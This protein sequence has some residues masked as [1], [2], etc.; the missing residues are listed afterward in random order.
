MGI[1][2]YLLSNTFNMTMAV[3][4]V[5]Q[6]V[7]N[8]AAGVLSHDT[9]ID[10]TALIAQ[11]ETAMVDMEIGA[12]VVLALESLVVSLGM[13]L[14]SIV[15]TV[16]CYGRMIEIYL[17]ISVAPIPFATLTNR[18]WGQ[19]GSNYLR[20][21]FAL[22]FQA[23]LMM[24]IGPTKSG[25]STLVNLLARDIVSPT[26]VAECTIRPSIIAKK[27]DSVHDDIIVY[28][29]KND[30]KESKVDCLDAVVN[31]LKGTGS[32]KDEFI[33]DSSETHSIREL[34]NVITNHIFT[35]DNTVITAV[36]VDASEGILSNNGSDENQIFLVDM[37][38]FDGAIVKSEHDDEYLYKAMTER[39]DLILFVQSSVSAIL[40]SSTEYFK[41]LRESCSKNV[42]I[43]LINN[44]YDSKSW[45]KG[46]N[47]D[48][49]KRQEDIAVTA[50]YE[51]GIMIYDRKQN[52]VSIN[53]GM[54][55]DHYFK[56]KENI[57]IVGQE[58]SLKDEYDKFKEFEKI[59]KVNI[60][61]HINEIRLNNCKGKVSHAK[62][63]LVDAVVG[64]ITNLTQKMNDKNNLKNV[65]DGKQKD[66]QKGI[67]NDLHIIEKTD[68]EVYITNK[69]KAIFD[70]YRK[71]LD[72]PREMEAEE[73]NQKFQEAISEFESKLNEE[74]LKQAEGIYVGLYTNI[75]NIENIDRNDIVLQKKYQN[76]EYIKLNSINELVD[77]KGWDGKIFGWQT[78]FKFGTKYKKRERVNIYDGMVSVICN[79]SQKS[80]K[81]AIE[82]LEKDFMHSIEACFANLLSKIIT[83]EEENEIVKLT[84]LK[85]A[86][87][88]VNI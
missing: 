19:I 39:V 72:M 52:V 9:A 26:D 59:L 18:E 16:A 53:L 61:S 37:P 41:F 70:D 15:I 4:D 49:I 73:I 8:A 80:V 85:T 74:L 46:K 21:L 68:A 13:K 1:A 77:K 7:V 42:P 83:S 54:A 62:K 32:E 17:Y 55:Y 57:E 58:I 76:K 88:R 78:P 65:L 36:T 28:K 79:R 56:V 86:V 22:A 51:N 44:A 3:F 60:T 64:E 38:G 12:L 48:D 40:G 34:K 67:H 23:F 29:S 31:I 82:N 20:G 35:N 24:V 30:G 71:F 2:V 63:D 11:T 43:F 10:V 75:S 5:G 81:D 6:H 69:A 33:V 87:D 50:L 25:K 14:M 45:R 47:T 27:S 66:L 84:E